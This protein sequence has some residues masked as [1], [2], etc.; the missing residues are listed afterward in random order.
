MRSTTI[1]RPSAEPEP[2]AEATQRRG[3]LRAPR[4]RR[5]LLST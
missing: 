2:E 5:G 4:R 1:E 3:Q